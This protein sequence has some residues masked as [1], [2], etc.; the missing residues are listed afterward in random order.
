[1]S[2]LQR[3]S[4]CKCMKLLS[5]FKVREN[6]GKLLKTCIKCCERFKCDKCDKKFSIISKLQRHINTVHYK[7]KDYECSYDQCDSK[8]SENSDLQNHIKSV[9]EGRKDFEC[10]YEDCDSKF[11]CNGN[12]QRHI[13][14]YHEGRKDFECTY[15]DCDSKFS[16]NNNLQVH[17]KSVHEGRKD[18]KCDK[19]DRNY[20]SKSH[21]HQHIK[22][23]HDKIKDFE[24]DKCDYKC[25]KLVHLQTHIK[26]CTGK[27]NLSSGEFKVI[28]CL[29]ELGFYKDDDYIHNSTFPELTKY[30]GRHLR[31]DFCFINHKRVFE[32]DGEQHE[33][34]V[35]FGGISQEQAERN[36]K[37]LK[38]CDKL[39]DDF[40]RE[41]GYKMV[42]ISYRDYPNIL[43]ILHCE[44][45]DIMDK[46][47]LY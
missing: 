36:F 14:G 26:I 27:S 38:E 33:R 22:S 43:S 17:I 9:H 37:D 8:F 46:L 4:M 35:C 1:M 23:V 44:L 40:C 2:E 11:S 16:E 24:C 45:L 28:E 41:N 29:K 39:K 19:C 10:T 42:R 34:A 25:S 12:L 6:T 20:T 47:L 13:K 3:C 32:F 5:L 15:E 30:S 31:F 18:F 7:I 21:L